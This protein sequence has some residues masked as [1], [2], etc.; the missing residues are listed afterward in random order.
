[1]TVGSESGMKTTSFVYCVGHFSKGDWRGKF[2][3]NFAYML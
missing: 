1:M 3:N 2:Y